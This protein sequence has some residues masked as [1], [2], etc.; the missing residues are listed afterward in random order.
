MYPRKGSC[1]GKLAAA[2]FLAL[3]LS[4]VLCVTPCQAAPWRFVVVGDTR[5]SDSWGINNTIVSELA[6]QIAGLSIKPGLVLVPGDLVNSG[7]TSG[8]F[9]KW[10]EYMA[11]VYGAGIA[12]YPIIGNH[13]SSG[14]T[15]WNTVFGPDIPDNGPVGE[16]NRTYAVSYNNALILNLDVYVNSHRVNQTWINAQLAARDPATTP[17][18]F[19]QGHEMAFKAVSHTDCLDDYS[20]NRNTFWNSIASAGGRS[21]FAGHD[22]TYD[23]ARIDDGDGNPNDDV[24]QYIVGSGGAPFHSGPAVYNGNNSPFT[25]INV[26]TETQYGYLIVDIDGPKATYT[27]MHRTGTNTYLPG[28]DVFSYVVPEPSTLLLLSMGVLALLAYAWQRR[29]GRQPPNLAVTAGWWRSS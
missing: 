7:S 29:W 15:S 20:A 1:A 27:W 18:L 5:G 28:G 16:V 13:D 21:Y 17:H 6:R 19:V 24:H 22:H 4:A 10:K 25:P 2:H 23:H 14:L 12:V 3:S 9:S 11:P 8:A 26:R